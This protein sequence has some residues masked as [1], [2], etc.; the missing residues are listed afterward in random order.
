MAFKPASTLEAFNDDV[1]RFI[2]DNNCQTTPF[3]RYVPRSGGT[4]GYESLQNADCCETSV[5]SFY[6]LAKS[7][8]IR[9]WQSF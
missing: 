5:L 4:R 2:A 9:G 1:D 6:N 8:G 7:F 3:N